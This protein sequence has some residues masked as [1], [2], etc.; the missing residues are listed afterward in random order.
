VL[1]VATLLQWWKNLVI[2]DVKYLKFYSC[3]HKNV[4]NDRIYVSVGIVGLSHDRAS[5]VCDFPRGG[6]SVEVCV[7]EFGLKRSGE[8]CFWSAVCDSLGPPVNAVFV[9]YCQQSAFLHVAVASSFPCAA[10]PVCPVH[11]ATNRPTGVTLKCLPMKNPPW[12][13]NHECD[14]S[15]H[16]I[17]ISPAP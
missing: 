5:C 9:L 4:Q 1:P 2:D 11:V 6:V 14:Y 10:F 17:K 3:S 15:F 13:D 12:R 16:L 7:M 8:F